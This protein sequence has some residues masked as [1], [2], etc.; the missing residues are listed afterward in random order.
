MREWL[1]TSQ[2]AQLLNVSERRIRQRLESG[3]LQGE[4]VGKNWRV[5]PSDLFILQL[6]T[7][8][9]PQR[10]DPT[11]F[12]LAARLA[13]VENQLKSLE[14]RLAAIESRLDRK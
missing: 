9:D 6:S 8:A 12:L 2:A 14:E 7:L 1:T 5:D 4:K 11:A 10:T 3:D 13:A